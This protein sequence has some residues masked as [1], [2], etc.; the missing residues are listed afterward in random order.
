[1]K[2]KLVGHIIFTLMMISLMCSINESQAADRKFGYGLKIGLNVA[3]YTN[4]RGTPR[5]GL[6]GG[7]FVDYNFHRLFG[8]ETGLF[9]S[10]QGS[11]SVSESGYIGFTQHKFDYLSI[12]I[13]F[14]YYLI[15]GFRI[16]AGPQASIMISAKRNYR[17]D[18]GSWTVANMKGVNNYDLSVV[19][20]VG[21]NFS[22][23]LDLGV[24]FTYGLSQL[25]INSVG[26]K[27]NTSMV[28]VT[29]GWRF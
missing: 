25:K 24:S 14:K 16:F 13:Y 10:Q 29:A 6:Y 3:D 18:E 11:N 23:G 27:H 15:P 22:F 9:Y 5:Y 21:Y 26:G 28:R 7:A 12:P 8:M 2:N 17:T 19:A 4:S 1:M 20:G